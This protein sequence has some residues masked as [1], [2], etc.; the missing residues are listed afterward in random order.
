MFHNDAVMQVKE[1]FL[2]TLG[3]CLPVKKEDCQ[4]TVFLRFFQDI[5]RLFAPLM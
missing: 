2:K 5:L 3:R 1:D 4:G